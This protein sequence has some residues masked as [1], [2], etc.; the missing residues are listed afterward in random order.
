VQYLVEVQPRLNP[1]DAVDRLWDRYGDPTARFRITAMSVVDGGCEWNGT[2]VRLIADYVAKGHDR[3]DV[4]RKIQDVCGNHAGH[5]MA[6]EI[7]RVNLYYPLL[8]D[9]PT[10]DELYERAGETEVL[11][12]IRSL[13]KPGAVIARE[14]AHHF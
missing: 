5:L 1:H 13:G 11:A 7:K 8:P 14:A 9:I 2:T 4:R 12:R 6:T 3:F 10:E